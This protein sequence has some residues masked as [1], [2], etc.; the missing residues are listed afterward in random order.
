MIDLDPQSRASAWLERAWLARYLD[1]TLDEDEVARFEAYVLDKPELLGEIDAD[2]AVR[3][4]LA[5]ASPQA[6]AAGVEP[7]AAATGG[8]AAD[9]AAPSRAAPPRRLMPWFAAAA[10]LLL[11]LALGQRLV[12]DGAGQVQASPGRVVFDTLRGEGLKPRWEAAATDQ[13]SL[14]I[15]DVAVVS[16]AQKI[17]ARL[18]DGR[19]LELRPSSEGF[20]TFV[21]PRKL[22]AGKTVQFSVTGADGK[23]HERTLEFSQ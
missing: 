19:E 9:T 5:A 15:V 22:L 7:A 13:T 2:T 17:T 16:D 20:A 21:A 12:G 10:S 23:R 3:D 11:G 4:S 1:R 6:L 14:L 8:V 18:P